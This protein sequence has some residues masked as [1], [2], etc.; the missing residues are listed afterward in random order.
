MTIF[1]KKNK[2]EQIIS[3]EVTPLKQSNLSS[4]KKIYPVLNYKDTNMLKIVQSVYENKKPSNA[5][6]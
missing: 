5:Y 2:L 6:Q 1:K 4:D 3:K